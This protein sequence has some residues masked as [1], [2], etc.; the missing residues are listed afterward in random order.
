MGLVFKG[1]SYRK[2]LKQNCRICQQ[3]KPRW[4]WEVDNNEDRSVELPQGDPEESGDPGHR[5]LKEM[6]L[7][8]GR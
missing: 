5:E 7:L 8:S 2:R 4:S 1:P 3:N 6:L